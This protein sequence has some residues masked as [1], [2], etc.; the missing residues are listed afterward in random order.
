MIAHQWHQLA[1]LTEDNKLVQRTRAA[2]APIDVI[3]QGDNSVS[4]FGL[5]GFDQSCQS[6]RASLRN[7]ITR[8]AQWAC[9]PPHS[10]D[11]ADLR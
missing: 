5:D 11:A 9:A 4:W 6:Q 10:T 3:T 1:L 8:Q 2:L 7:S